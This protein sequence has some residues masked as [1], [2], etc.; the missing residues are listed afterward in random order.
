M[1]TLGTHRVLTWVSQ[2]EGSWEG[3]EKATK[4]QG[5]EVGLPR[6]QG[7]CCSFL[8]SGRRGLL[9]CPLVPR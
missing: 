6:E 3:Q 5:V 1:K 7:P 8:Y 4:W 2:L 9:L